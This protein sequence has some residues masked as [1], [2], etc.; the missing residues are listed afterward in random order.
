MRS[1]HAELAQAQKQV[2]RLQ[3]DCARYAAL[4]RIAQRTVGLS[5]PQTP[6]S[7]GKVPGK[8]RRKSQTARAL[9]A[10]QS[11]QSAASGEAEAVTAGEQ[12]AKE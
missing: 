9:R 4:V 8:R 10:V 6:K 12:S 7:N 2:R 1:A 11:L 3:Q 5:A